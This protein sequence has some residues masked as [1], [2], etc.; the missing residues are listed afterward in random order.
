MLIC[1]KMFIAIFVMSCGILSA[2]NLL[3][4]NIKNS[5]EAVAK[6]DT[7]ATAKLSALY[8]VTGNIKEKQIEQYI[9]S[10]ADVMPG[11]EQTIYDGDFIIIAKE[12]SIISS[13]ARKIKK[14][15]E[16]IKKEIAN[17]FM[18]SF[19]IS[20]GVKPLLFW[21]KIWYKVLK[22]EIHNY[23]AENISTLQKISLVE[24]RL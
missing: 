13:A 1:K 7:Q 16:N 14:D 24:H 5:W 3:D 17:T 21:P 19:L 6:G 15:S 10:A 18:D 4:R 2:D 12:A 23:C 8:L 20:D 11:V 9:Q 22:G